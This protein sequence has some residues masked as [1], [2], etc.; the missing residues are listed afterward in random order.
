[1]CPRLG[2]KRELNSDED[3]DGDRK[4]EEDND[5]GEMVTSS[6][7]SIAHSYYQRMTFKE[8]DDNTE[9]E[10]EDSISLRRSKRVTKGKRFAFWKGERPVY[11]QVRDLLQWDNML[12]RLFSAYEGN[13]GG[14]THCG[15]YSQEAEEAKH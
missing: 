6:G 2:K 8:E 5:D 14:A 7:M 15:A 1:M 13:D 11:N 10:E 3:E 4:G 9:E 12:Y